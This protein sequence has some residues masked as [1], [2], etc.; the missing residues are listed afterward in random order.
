[1]LLPETMKDHLW[2]PF[3]IESSCKLLCEIGLIRV[4]AANAFL[5]SFDRGEVFGFCEIGRNGCF[6]IGNLRFEI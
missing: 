1:M 5:D 4:A 2:R 3:I 6:R